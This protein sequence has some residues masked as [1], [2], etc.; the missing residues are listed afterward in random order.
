MTSPQNE[1]QTPPIDGW[2][3]Q[4]HDTAPT[5][6]ADRIGGL[7]DLELEYGCQL[8]VTASTL[9]E[10]E[11]RCIAE[12]VKAGLV[13]A[14]ERLAERMLEAELARRS[15]ARTARMSGPGGGINA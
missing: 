12:N 5:W 15:D 4:R 2:R 8:R 6:T 9:G 10:L 13:Q 7:S 1:H 14:A 3:V 11:V